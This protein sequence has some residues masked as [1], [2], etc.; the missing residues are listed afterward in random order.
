MLKR[1]GGETKRLTGKGHVRQFAE[2][3]SLAYSHSIPPTTYYLFRL[4]DD[5]PRRNV[6]RY[7]H[8]FETKTGLFAFLNCNLGDEAAHDLMGNKQA[9]A[10][11]CIER[12]L[13]TPE[14]YL[15]VEDGE[16]VPRCWDQPGLPRNDIIVKRREGKGGHVMMRWEVQPDGRY[17]GDTGEC[18][19]AEGVLDLLRHDSH[20][21]AL[22][23]VRRVVNH[24]DILCMA[25][26]EEKILT[27]C[28]LVTGLNEAGVP[29]VLS[30]T[31]KIAVDQ[32]VADNVHFGGLASPVD[33]HTGSLG[34]GIETSPLGVPVD[35]HPVSGAPI[36]GAKLPMW[37]DVL[38]LVKRA[39]E[40][41]PEAIFVGWDVGLTPDGP[42]LVEG[43]SA[44]CVHLQQ[45]PQGAPLG[46]GRFGEIMA[47]HLERIDWE[48]AAY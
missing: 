43:N 39:H 3:L 32:S 42:T 26:S 31:F 15:E 29:E 16:V 23:A 47:Y 44:K 22:I 34:P 36:A 4:F 35:V 8:R 13:P 28:R 9:F 11:R 6:S 14:V 46:A 30:S 40:G 12:N 27:T 10:Q 21:M 33:V 25:G 41:F 19:D 38:A 18:L 24:P 1:Y 20:S 2:L 5:E 17:L 48:S 7:I 37:D 45:T